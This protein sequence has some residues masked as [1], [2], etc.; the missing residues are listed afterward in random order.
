MEAKN[1][2]IFWKHVL[3]H[4][5]GNNQMLTQTVFPG[6]LQK[7]SRIMGKSLQWT[8]GKIPVESQWNH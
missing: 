4:L 7:S 1:L 2:W 5:Q 3:L 8:V 6:V